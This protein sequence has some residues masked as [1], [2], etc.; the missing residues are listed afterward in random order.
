ML[1]VFLFSIKA[2][3]ITSIDTV[4]SSIFCSNL[5]AEITTVPNCSLV[6][7]NEIFIVLFSPST[8]VI[9]FTMSSY[10]M[11][12][13]VTFCM[14]T[15]AFRLYFPNTSVAV[16]VP[17]LSIIFTPMSFSLLWLSVMVPFMFCP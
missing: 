10:P 11:Y 5:P 7:V 9:S 8:N 12:R 16:P 2:G 4:I 1:V 17:L 3:F 13:K 6:C 15:T 14:P